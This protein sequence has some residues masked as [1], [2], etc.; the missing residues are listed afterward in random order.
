[1]QENCLVIEVDADFQHVVQDFIKYKEQFRGV[2]GRVRLDLKIH[3]HLSLELLG[4]CHNVDV[5]ACC[6]DMSESF[7]NMLIFYQTGPKKFRSIFLFFEHLSFQR[8][9]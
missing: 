4:I 1:M 5:L 7:L 3:M 9:Y 6:D 2:S 8:V